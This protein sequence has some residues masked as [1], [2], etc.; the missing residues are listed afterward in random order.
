[1]DY[2]DLKK[3]AVQRGITIKSLAEM[4][5]LTTQ[6]IHKMVRNNNSTVRDL[7]LISNALGVSMMYWW[8]TE[9]NELIIFQ[10]RKLKCSET[11]ILMAKSK[12]I[13]IMEAHQE[14]IL[15]LKRM[16]EDSDYKCAG[17]RLQI[18]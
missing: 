18:G 8:N 6:G 16:L 12:H 7:E 4:T 17:N 15:R 13:R 1:M 9:K 11:E 2:G 5:G 10:D 3:L 14:E